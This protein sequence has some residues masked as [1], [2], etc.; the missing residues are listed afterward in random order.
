V[1]TPGKNG[2]LGFRRKQE[3]AVIAKR[4]KRGKPTETGPSVA[5]LPESHE[6]CGYADNEG[7]D[8][9][10]GVHSGSRKPRLARP[11]SKVVSGTGK[12]QVPAPDAEQAYGASKGASRRRKPPSLKGSPTS[13]S[14]SL[15]LNSLAHQS[16]PGE[17]VEPSDGVGDL[18]CREAGDAGT[19]LGVSGGE[20]GGIESPSCSLEEGLR[21]KRDR[22]R[23]RG[24]AVR[25]DSRAPRSVEPAPAR[26][27]SS[28]ANGRQGRRGVAESNDLVACY[29]AEISKVPLLTHEQVTALAR[30]IEAAKIAEERLSVMGEPEPVLEAQLIKVVED[31][32]RAKRQ[33][34][35]SNLRLVVSVAK[36]FTRYGVPLMDLV[37]EG[38][39]GLI[40]AVERYDYRKGYR[41]STYAT[42]W[43]RQAILRALADQGRI[44]KIPSNIA[45]EASRV[46]RATNALYQRLG[47]EP[48]IDEVARE[49][50][51][52]PE[53]VAEL[54]SLTQGTVSLETPIGHDEQATLGDLI[55][56][57]EEAPHE[58]LTRRLAQ[59]QVREVIEALTERERQILK[60][61]F[62]L[63]G[64]R[65]KTLEEVGAEFNVTRERIRQIEAKTLA[66]LRHP[67]RACELDEYL[68]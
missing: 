43:I 21:T 12:K 24:Y 57:E 7:G 3:P 58:L 5:S 60:M 36:Y 25:S 15:Q 35:E 50:E 16:K 39:I 28:K 10:G 26:R 56:D 13:E 62:G 63:D 8:G 1:S 31:G 67:S 30:R 68:G 20:D 59:E 27:R 47:R 22:G 40:R 44:I 38:N 55:A 66:K 19:S 53:R 9:S 23:N 17:V 37:Q 34:I 65:P 2:N 6:D 32:L 48:R 29:F 51:L 61:R 42:W 41:F 33:L 49:S 11:S 52:S 54:L 4:T 14:G 46:N 45:D 18:N 64:S